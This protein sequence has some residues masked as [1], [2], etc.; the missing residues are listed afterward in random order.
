[1][2]MCNSTSITFNT[3]LVV[4]VNPCFYT[5][6]DT[7]KIIT[8]RIMVRRWWVLTEPEISDIFGYENLQFEIINSTVTPTTLEYT[9]KYLPPKNSRNSNVSLN[10]L[11]C[12]IKNKLSSYVESSPPLSIKFLKTKHYSDNDNYNTYFCLYKNNIRI[13]YCLTKPT[14][15]L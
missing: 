7:I 10:E 14:K 9:L 3:P 8:N 13:Q 4:T 1:M 12:H 6:G 2:G 5:I 15:P 11:K